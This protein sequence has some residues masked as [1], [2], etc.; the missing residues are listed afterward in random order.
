MVL[1]IRWDVELEV[2]LGQAF[3][4]EMYHILEAVV[5]VWQ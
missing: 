5:E 3:S 2:Y 4:D 1:R